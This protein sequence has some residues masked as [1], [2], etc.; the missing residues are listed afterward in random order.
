VEAKLIG[1]SAMW[2][3]RSATTWRVT[4]LAKSLE[5]A[6]GPTNT[7]LPV[8]VDTHTHTPHFGESTCKTLFLSVVVRHSLVGRVARL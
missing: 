7:P 1:R 6:R 5:L 2:L 8:K 4:A 3:G